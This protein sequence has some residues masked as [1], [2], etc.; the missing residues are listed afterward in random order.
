MFSCTPDI[1]GPARSPTSPSLSLSLTVA[2]TNVCRRGIKIGYPAGSET[3]AS[4]TLFSVSSVPPGRAVLDS[5][6][7]S[8][9]RSASATAAATAAR[10]ARFSP[11][12]AIGLVAAICDLIKLEHETAFASHAS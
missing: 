2:V 3:S 7:L 5:R 6:R 10:T 8:Q 4:T 12:A 11:R 1:I 9:D